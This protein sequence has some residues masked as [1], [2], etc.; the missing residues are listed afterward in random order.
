MLDRALE[1][2]YARWGARYPK[3]ALT[4]QFQ[5]SHV[6]V[7]AGV[8]LLTVYQPMST[9]EFL[10]VVVVSQALVLLDNVLALKQ[11]FRLL[12]PAGVWLRGNRNPD[13]TVAAWRALVNMPTEFVRRH[14]PFPFF[15]T[16]VPLCVYITAEL[17]LPAYS[18]LIL[19]A[20]ALVVIAYG[21]MLRF[22]GMELIL[23]PVVRDVGRALPDGVPLPSAG[24]SLRAKLLLG[25]P[26]INIITGVAVA[27]LSTN[28]PAKL[29]D[30][31]LDVIVAV[32]VA[33][34]LSLELTLLLARS[35]LGPIDDLR[36]ATRQV[37]RGDL[38]ARVPVLS[39]DETGNLTQSFNLA[40][41]GLQER[42]RLREAFGTY[43]DPDVAARIVEEG[44]VLQGDD[45]EVS[46]LFLDI[47][48]FTAFA[49]RA[50]A[51]EVVTTLNRFWELVVPAVTECGG[52][53]N[54]FIGDG[55][56]A[57]FGA[58]ERQRDHADRAVR[59][60]IGIV[61]RIRAEYAG[62]LRVGVGVNSG[63]VVAGTIG[64][65][66]RLE[67]TV[68]GDTVNTAARVERVTR[69]TGHEMLITQATH[70][71]LG[72]DHGGFEECGR[73][74]LKGK[75]E[76]VRLYSPVIL[77]AADYASALATRAA[78]TSD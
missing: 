68:I 31:G 8:G 78:A 75:S 13:Q 70:A 61:R 21:V 65:G 50:S 26:L 48:D 29:S 25:L 45:V 3:A 49:E 34:T 27:G 28:G 32:G 46:V 18:V 4:I 47:R 64:G 52:H 40:L 60:G 62:E 38:S 74:Q 56:L 9:T 63:P 7:L 20:G 57:V 41:Q 5:L 16:T 42:E 35:I 39:T 17:G 23:R 51:R 15:C 6:I 43:V 72:S 73:E 22:F 19:L 14:W 59:C 69:T 53:A 66:G 12:R 33:F 2:A 11:V 36:A 77:G 55:L 58:P 54:K 37:A 1:W 67:F 10:R 44:A 76:E 71:L 24:M 30:L